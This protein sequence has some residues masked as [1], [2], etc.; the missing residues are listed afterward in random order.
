MIAF[1]LYLF[2]KGVDPRSVKVT[3]HMMLFTGRVGIVEMTRN[4]QSQL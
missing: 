1:I 4:R 3:C 2:K